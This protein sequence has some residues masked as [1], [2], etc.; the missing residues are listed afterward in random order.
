MNA[1]TLRGTAASRRAALA[2]V[3]AL[4]LLA[5]AA[6]SADSGDGTG[7]GDAATSGTESGAGAAFPVTVDTAFG[8]VEIPEEPT[9]V[10]ALG[11]GDAET[12]LALGVEPVGASDWLAFGGDGV[13]PWLEDAYTE[14]PEIIGTLEP[15]YEQ[16]ALLD[17][18]VILDV[19]SSGDAERY[20]RLSEIAPTVG[21]PEGGESYLASLDDQVSMIA[22]ALGRAD[23]GED[24]LAEVDDAFAGAREENP[25]F[26]GKTAVIGSYWAEG[27]GAYVSSSS[28]GEFMQKLGFVTKPEIDEAA[29]EEF[30]ANLG[31][32]NVALLDADLTV[33]QP[34]G[35][36]AADVE[37]QPA[38]Q[39]VPSVVDGR[40]VVFDDPDLSSA[41]S[42]GTPTAM[43]YAIDNV[44]PLFA[45]ALAG[46]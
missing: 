1:L 37:A 34:I 2:G 42:L 24:L 20:E 10:V 46:S 7:D 9:R 22:A 36:T 39:T 26:E 44:V 40:Y 4:A 28:R 14:S 16:I 33:I 19:K 18:D 3:S 23:A 35:F 6:C 32:E 27:F 17:P 41:F 38:F 11:W 5:L 13:G 31:T 43:I 29:G 8:E 12:A 21:V 25:D 30:S 45:E 15:S